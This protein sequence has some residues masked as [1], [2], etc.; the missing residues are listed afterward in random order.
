MPHNPQR[1][2]RVSLLAI[3]ALAVAIVVLSTAAAGAHPMRSLT[4]NVSEE[5]TTGTLQEPIAETPA[6]SPAG[7]ASGETSREQRHRR[8]EE[9]R[10]RRQARRAGNQLSPATG[11]SVTLKATPSL[12]AFEAPLSLTGALT[13]P[14]ASSAAGQTVTL[15]EMLA[16]AGAFHEA[17]TTA[18]EADGTF[19]FSPAGL[20][21]NSS[22]YASADGAQSETASV[23]VTPL[24]TI[25]AP[26]AGTQLPV[27]S[28]RA[29]RADA[30]PDSADTVTFTGTVLPANAGPRVALQR[31]DGNGAWSR[32][33]S[34]T[35]NAEGAYSIP[36]TFLRPGRANIR[37]VVHGHGLTMKAVSATVT[38]QIARRRYRPVPN[39]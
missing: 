25:L 16:H 11:C 22:F 36:H 23:K 5:G 9:R 17:A 4:S 3:A 28:G 34:G 1:A 10:E 21:V 12:V 27:G 31:E 30:S 24:V 33:G 19:Q 18:T 37:V 20:A 13:C 38:Y 7:E 6:E 2:L 26:L 15:Y 32:I 14:E 35:V 8:H 29:Q 39:G